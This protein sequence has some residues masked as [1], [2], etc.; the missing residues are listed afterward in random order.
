MRFESPHC[1]RIDIS[2]ETARAGRTEVSHTYSRIFRRHCIEL[3]M[4]QHRSR[5]RRMILSV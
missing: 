2:K 3:N 4:L 1:K 5:S